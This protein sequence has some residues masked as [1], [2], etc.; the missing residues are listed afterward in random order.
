MSH[1]LVMISYGINLQEHILTVG[2][3]DENY[4][5]LKQRLQ[6]QVEGD[7][8]EEYHL[9]EDGLVIF[10]NKIYVLDRIKLKKLNLIEFHV[11]PYSGHPGYQ[12]TL[13]IVKKFYYWTNL[14][15]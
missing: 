10:R 13:T 2:K 12:K 6:Q 14:K 4:H 3:H 11:N 1:I 9:T 7:K 5:Q 15:K 8:D